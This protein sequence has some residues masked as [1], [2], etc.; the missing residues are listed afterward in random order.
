[1]LMMPQEC[2]LVKVLNFIIP[3]FMVLMPPTLFISIFFLK[4]D[5]KHW[6]K[7]LWMFVLAVGLLSFAYVPNPEG[8]GDLLRYLERA[9]IYNNYTIREVLRLFYWEET[10]STIWL[11]LVSKSG[12]YG[13][14]N[15]IPT[16]TVYAIAN[17]ITYDYSEKHKTLDK[18]FNLLLLQIILLPFISITY[19]IF[20]VFAF[21]L[22]VFA[23][24]RELVQHKRD[25]ITLALY[26]FPCFIHVAGVSLLLVRL[27]A[28]FINNKVTRV[29]ALIIAVF[30]QAIFSFAYSHIDFFSKIRP[31]YNAIDR[32]GFY[33]YKDDSA[34][35]LAVS[36]SFW[37]RVLYI[38]YMI[39]AV[40]TILLYFRTMKNEEANHTMLTINIKNKELVFCNFLYII[41]IVCIGC[42]I[43]SVP[44]YWRFALAA[45]LG[46]NVLVIRNF[47]NESARNQTP[48]KMLI[49][50]GLII[51]LL[52]VYK[53][54]VYV[55]LL[56]TIYNF[57]LSSPIII[58]FR[59][60]WALFAL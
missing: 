57:L 55:Q 6:R 52:Y 27:V 20:C 30:S 37:Y 33:L 50:S 5:Y 51:T 26:I 43:F 16:T 54:P 15:G 9:E 13:L 56:E 12:I 42:T 11:W 17:Y 10:G 18:A 23:A 47:K 36:A 1:M 59:L 22:I 49:L 25:L 45:T 14:L 2:E 38:G 21:A 4:R 58:V 40:S 31:L 48:I 39:F 44:H 41:S 35:S 46:L 8:G 24:Y 7:Y 3:F 60:I 19:N 28:S 53:V 34:Y 29:A 32:V